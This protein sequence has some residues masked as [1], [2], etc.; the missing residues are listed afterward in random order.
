MLTRVRRP[1]SQQ[2]EP[3]IDLRTKRLRQ[4]FDPFPEQRPFLT[5]DTRHV[6]QSSTA[7]ITASSARPPRMR[8]EGGV[9]TTL[10]AFVDVEQSSPTRHPSARPFDFT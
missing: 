1:R 5:R 10:D 3:T 6:G 4:S 8:T 2:R 9:R 7:E